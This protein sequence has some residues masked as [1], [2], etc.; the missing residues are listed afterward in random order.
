MALHYKI[1]LTDE[2]FQ[3]DSLN[4]FLSNAPNTNTL[5]QLISQF[6]RWSLHPKE[7]N[8]KNSIVLNIVM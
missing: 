7:K 5:R 4:N 8:Q 2:I 1:D 6:N 3:N